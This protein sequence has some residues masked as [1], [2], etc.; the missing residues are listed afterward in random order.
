MRK[1]VALICIF[2]LTAPLVAR[3]PVHAKHGM[4]VS[5][6]SHATDVGVAVMQSGG[7]AVDAAVAVAFA[8]AVT[9]PFGGNIGGGGFMLVHMADG[10]STFLDFRE[11]AT[12]SA[13]RNMY[14]DPATGKATRES[15]QGY[16]SAGI[17]GTVRGLESAHQKFGKKAWKDLVQPAINLATDG[18]E[19]SFERMRIP[20]SAAKLSQYPDSKRIFLKNGVPYEVGDTFK[21]PDLAKTL[22]RI[23][24][25]GA[26]DF[27]EGET[28][29]MLAKDMAD[30]HGEITLDD[31]K[32]Y[33]VREL[34]PLEGAYKGYT[35]LTSP[36]P[37]SGG[38]GI[39][40]MMGIL[41]GTDYTKSGPGSAYALHYEAEAM[42]RC[43]ADRSQY[44][45]DPD[46]VKVPVASLIEPAYLTKLRASIDRAKATP[47]SEVR[48]ADPATFGL[49]PTESH[50]TTHFSVVDAEGNA[51]SLTYTLNG[52]F[53][54]GVTAT[55]LGF[56]LNNEMDDFASEPGRA[57]MFGLIQG[58]ANAIAPGKTPV[59][60][61]SPT[62]LLKDG[63]VFLVTGS[64]G[65]STIVNTVLQVI[66]NVVDFHMNV[67]EAVDQTRIHHQWMPDALS[68]EKTV[69]PDT[70]ELL[71][72]R[73]HSIRVQGVLGDVQTIL[74]DGGWVQGAADGRGEGTAKG[75]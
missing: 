6:E 54:S 43:Y 10:R 42:R 74:V 34:K 52:G 48:A 27:Y 72:Q 5:R 67:Q 26:K 36:P 18:F 24:D 50:E 47:S 49:L 46:F 28:A 22:S 61:M 73:G 3:Q 51:V 66:L 55:G 35:V 41:G 33:K 23:R 59:S 32:N 63:K 57:N 19:M 13:S 38:I 39:L 2:S 1:I 65:G 11:R 4:V 37:S 12:K 15:T 21:Q 62:I 44:L 56:L 53:G 75:Y 64:P 60:S 69:P 17:P 71:K 25:V 16:R 68:V 9:Y 14:I 30:H 20:E 7:N 58:E 70:I 29:R 45:G 8:L 40:Q 31:L